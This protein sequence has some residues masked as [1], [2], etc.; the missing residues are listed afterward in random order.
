MTILIILALF[1]VVILHI[2]MSGD[3]SS[4]SHYQ[5]INDLHADMEWEDSLLANEEAE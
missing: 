3:K 1:A 4:Y 2:V 5:Y